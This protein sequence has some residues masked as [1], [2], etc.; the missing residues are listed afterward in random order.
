VSLVS[1]NSLGTASGNND[2]DG[3]LVSADG[4]YVLFA[5]VAT[6][7]VTN[8]NGY[9]NLF[10]RDLQTGTTIPVEVNRNGANGANGPSGSAYLSTSGRHVAFESFATDLVSTPDNNSTV[11]VFIRDLQTGT[12]TL[13]SVNRFGAAAGNGPSYSPKVSADGRFVV[14]TS[15]ATD[16]VENYRPGEQGLFVRDIVAG[17]TTL[18]VSGIPESRII[19]EK[20][21]PGLRSAAGPS[22]SNIQP[23]IDAVEVKDY[24]P[25]V[26]ADG[27]F[28]AFTCYTDLMLNYNNGAGVAK[29]FLRDLYAGTTSPVRVDRGTSAEGAV[30]GI[31]ADAR[32]VL[33][34]NDIP[35]NAVQ[36]F[37]RRNSYNLYVRDMLKQE[38]QL[39]TISIDGHSDARNSDGGDVLI[40]D[41]A[42]SADG[43]FVVFVTRAINL[44]PEKNTIDF[45]DIFVR[46]LVAG[47]TK[48]V[49]VN[50]WGTASG[51][52]QS[53]LPRISGDGRFIAFY[54]RASDLVYNDNDRPDF[55]E[56]VFVRDTKLGITTLASINRTGTASGNDW[57]EVPNLSTDGRRAVF[58]SAASDL[59]PID[60]RGVKNIFA[61]TVPTRFGQVQFSAP[62]YQ[63][64]EGD[65]AAT[66]T[67]SRTDGSEGNVSI[68]YAT[69]GGTASSRSNYTP[70][71]GTLH[72][73]PGEVS[74]TFKVLITDDQIANG[75]KTVNLALSNPAGGVTLGSQ[76]TATLTIKDNDSTTSNV[77]PIDESRFYVRQHYLDFLNR[78]PDP[79]GLQFWTNQIE[80]CGADARCRQHK[81]INVSAAFI[82]STEFQE[83]GFL[84]YRMY[85]AA[86]GRAPTY[87][88]F[89]ADI[90]AISQGVVVGAPGWEAELELNK[91][92]F[93]DV[94]A[95]RTS[96]ASIY[97]AKTVAEYYNTLIANTGITPS[98]DERNALLDGLSDGKVTRAATLVK[99]A[100]LPAFVQK[101]FNPAFVLM[102]YFGYLRRNPNDAPDSDFSGYNF[103]LNKLNQFG[104]NYQAAEMVKAFINSTEYRQRF[105]P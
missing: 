27:R 46:D 96:F 32:F 54:S 53:F 8:T 62:S 48:V 76:S 93:A 68:D 30:I 28:L 101:E 23:Q 40:H 89:L 35:S 104:G 2:S 29:G 26:S 102:Q 33:W 45:E 36:P 15:I 103:W 69:F 97:N 75:D 90:Q 12:N 37:S 16:L 98:S 17:T 58:T 71:F 105:G 92:I 24:H 18:I 1:V 41:G 19:V 95:G 88:E 13:V 83:T 86:Y 66:M 100:E 60:T 64:S 99:I 59:V 55:N 10:V 11:D 42:I 5:S 94:F 4:R 61:Y 34:T 43:R 22:L 38:A 70:A 91:Q 21:L 49:S 87:A 6:D 47:V 72:F 31:S 80:Q 3:T 63:A 39:V 77:N 14:F 25:I 7:L 79:A 81:R 20:S 85:K 57:S 65:G 9:L 56:D 44:A 52:R 67:V 73:L 51:N 82:L 84:V 74:K 78:E 50:A